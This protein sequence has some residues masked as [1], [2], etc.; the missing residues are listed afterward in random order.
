M[1]TTTTAETT[2]KAWVELL[3]VDSAAII[4]TKVSVKLSDLQETR[5]KKTSTAQPTTTKKTVNRAE[6]HAQSIS[7]NHLRS[8]QFYQMLKENKNNTLKTFTEAS[9]LFTDKEEPLKSNKTFS[10]T[11]MPLWLCLTKR[12]LKT[13]SQDTGYTNKEPE[14]CPPCTKESCEPKWLKFY[15]LITF[16]ARM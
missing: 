7:K 9:K 4:D 1:S 14:K 11:T 2:V 13:F 16:Y 10:P 5:V 15:E 12:I 6:A 3:V 8:L